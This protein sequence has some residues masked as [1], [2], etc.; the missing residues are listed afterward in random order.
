MEVNQA[1]EM[2]PPP[3][4][5]CSAPGCEFVTPAAIPTY[6]YV[7]KAL[8]LHVQ[9]AH[10]GSSRALTPKTE[11]PKRPALTTNMSESDWVFFQHKWERYKRLSQID[12]QLLIDELWACLDSEME[13]LAFQDGISDTDPNR[14]LNQIKSLAVTTVH[15][16]IHVVELHEAKQSPEETVKAFSARVR[17]IAANCKLSKTCSKQGCSES[18]SFLEETC[19]HA[20]LTGILNDDLREKILTQAMMGTVTN[21]PTLLEYAA[22]E[23]SAKQKTPPRNVAAIKKNLLYTYS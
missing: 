18:V 7:I 20:V 5:T 2:A 15:P 22:A 13:R 4:M 9:S 17:G 10:T 3:P 6:E 8:D 21:L 12:G 14:L 16:S 19:Y 11:K 23:E 1:C